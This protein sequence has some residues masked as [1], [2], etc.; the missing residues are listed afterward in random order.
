MLNTVKTG[1]SK[2]RAQRSTPEITPLRANY[3]L[4]LNTTYFKKV[5]ATYMNKECSDNQGILI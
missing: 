2:I 4:Y 1:N 3:F 5:M